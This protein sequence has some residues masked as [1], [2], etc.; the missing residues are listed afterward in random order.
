MYGLE[1]LLIL[2]VVVMMALVSMA[3]GFMVGIERGRQMERAHQQGMAMRRS[4]VDNAAFHNDVS[5]QM[6]QIERELAERA[7]LRPDFRF[8]YP[9]QSVSTS[10]SG[11]VQPLEFQSP[12]TKRPEY[13]QQALKNAGL[14]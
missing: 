12:Y 8:E 14:Q 2:A 7:Q 4:F 10:S 6:D 5:G 11:H 3:I 13:V 9:Q 1:A